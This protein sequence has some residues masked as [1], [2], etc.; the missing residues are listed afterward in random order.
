MLLINFCPAFHGVAPRPPHST[1]TWHKLFDRSLL[2]KQRANLTAMLMPQVMNN[3]I[4]SW[5]FKSQTVCLPIWSREA[6]RLAPCAVKKNMTSIFYSYHSDFFSRPELI[7]PNAAHDHKALFREWWAGSI[8][9]GNERACHGKAKRIFAYESWL[10]H[11]IWIKSKKLNVCCLL[12]SMPSNWIQN[13]IGSVW[14][15]FPQHQLSV[16]NNAERCWT[17][18]NDT[19][20]PSPWHT[21]LQSTD[22]AEHRNNGYFASLANSKKCGRYIEANNKQHIVSQIIHIG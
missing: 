20:R 19:L 21:Q 14:Q 1:S 11:I 9:L 7:D 4:D 5:N 8:T 22:P 12:S 16:R 3:E 10:Q 15:K 17:S 6:F 18:L 13:F 2:S